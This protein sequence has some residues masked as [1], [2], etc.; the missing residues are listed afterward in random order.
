[1]KYRTGGHFR[2]AIEAHVHALAH[3]SQRTPEGLRK[4]IAFDR[5]LSRLPQVAADRWVLK[6]G[7]ALDRR[8]RDR[9]RTTKDMAVIYCADR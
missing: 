4:E 7:L 3:G 2:D 9:A 5:L 6:G 8:L 1:M